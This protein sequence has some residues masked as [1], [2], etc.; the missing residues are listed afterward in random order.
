[1]SQ[2]RKID[3]SNSEGSAPDTKEHQTRQNGGL[4]D[5]SFALYRVLILFFF[6]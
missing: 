2:L 1:M 5:L 6:L 4:T 3:Y